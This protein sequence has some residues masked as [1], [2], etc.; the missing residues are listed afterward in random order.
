MSSAYKELFAFL[1]LH[2]LGMAMGRGGL[3]YLW[4]SAG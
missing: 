3:E 1:V 4:S 2:E